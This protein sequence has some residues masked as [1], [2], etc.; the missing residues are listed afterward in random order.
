M[1]GTF[2]MFVDIRKFKF[3]K[4]I[5]NPRKV[6][7]TNGGQQLRHTSGRCLVHIPSVTTFL[8]GRVKLIDFGTK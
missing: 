1:N 3:I 7:Q 8:Q 6:F 5:K 2:S 4:Q